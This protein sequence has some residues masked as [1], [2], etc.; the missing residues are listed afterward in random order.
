MPVDPPTDPVIP[1][2]GGPTASG[3]SALALGLAEAFGLE[4]VSADAMMVYRGLDIGTAKPTPEERVRVPH[5]LLDVAD[6]D[7][8]FSVA[9]FVRLAE[10]AIGDVLARGRLPLVVGGTGFYIRALTEG[11]PTVPAADPELQRPLWGRLR[12]EGLDALEAELYARNPAD[13]ARAQRNPRRVV[14]ALEVWER[15]GRSPASFP[16]TTPRFRYSKRR[17][18]P[19]P[20]ELGA[21]IVRRTEEMFAAGLVGE[22]SRLSERFPAAT[23]AFQAI[24]YKEV[25]AALLGAYPLED[26]PEAVTRA[27]LRYARRQRT[28]FAREPGAARLEPGAAGAWLGGLGV[29]R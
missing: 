22:V 12:R 28:W 7:E 21:R 23:T 3:K 14:R 13:A 24:G 6:P 29:P 26:A 16:L 19:E 15:T 5:H 9:R 27:T 20:P 17:L 8:A 1:V 25:R 18:E 11:L 10:A 2:L 4:L